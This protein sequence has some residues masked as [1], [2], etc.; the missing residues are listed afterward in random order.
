MPEIWSGSV[1]YVEVPV[2]FQVAGA[3]VSPIA[4]VV[5]L[6]FPV[7]GVNPIAGDWVTG[8]WESGGPPY[9]ARV[10]VGTGGKVLTPGNYDVWVRVTDSPEVPAMKAGFLKVT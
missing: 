4:D 1:Q 6:A 3:P 10:L 8:S 7:A 5:A 9:V 2:S